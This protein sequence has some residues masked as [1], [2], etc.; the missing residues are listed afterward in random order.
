MDRLHGGHAGT[1]RGNRFRTVRRQAQS[2]RS[3]QRCRVER[4]AVQQSRGP[5]LPVQHR[6]SP[7]SLRRLRL[8][9]AEPL[10]RHARL[11]R[12]DRR[13]LARVGRAPDSPVGRRSPNSVLFLTFDEGTSTAGGGGQIP[14]MVASPWTPPARGRSTTLTHYSLLRTIE[15]AWS[16]PPLGQAAAATAM[17]E[18]FLRPATPPTEQVIYASGHLRV[19]RRVDQGRR[20]H[21][22]RGREVVDAGRR[23]DVRRSESSGGPIELLRRDVPGVGRH[24][25]PRLAPHPSAERLQMERFGLRAV[26]RQRRRVKACRSIASARPAATSSIF[27]RARRARVRL[28]LATE[29][30]LAG[31]LRRR[32]VSR[33]AA[34]TRFGCRCAKT[35]P[36]SI[37]S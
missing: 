3:L 36:R 25:V 12:G 13:R 18:F 28:G 33:E 15:D 30:L 31:R 10:Q 9:H 4:G 11:F 20:C 1:L 5:L 7:S 35:A 32:L 17:A 23:R 37:R 19:H 8:D 16:L 27:G 2:L 21:R 22:R 24:T 14:L 29:C 6:L 26:L 34:P